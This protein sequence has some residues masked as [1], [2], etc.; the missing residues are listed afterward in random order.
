MNFRMEEDLNQL[1]Q[2]PKLYL[3]MMLSMMQKNTDA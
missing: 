1:F 2:I 3:S